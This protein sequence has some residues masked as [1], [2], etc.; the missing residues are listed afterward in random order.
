VGDLTLVGRA[1]PTL[2]SRVLP[3]HLRSET[4]SPA[5]AAIRELAEQLAA[6]GVR[7]VRGNIIADDT[8][9]VSD[10]Y[11]DDWSVGDLEWEYGAPV[12]ALAFNDNTLKLQ[13]QPGGAAGRQALIALDPVADYYQIENGVQTA[14]AGSETVI[15][16]YRAPSSM[17]LDLW[18]Q[19]PAGGETAVEEISIQNPPQLMGELLRQQLEARG[20]KVQGQ[21]MVRELTSIGAAT[22]PNPPAAPAAPRTTLAEHDSLPLREDIKLTLKVSQNLHAEMLLRTV[23]HEV[24][25]S[26]TVAAGLEVL[27]DFVA[28][29]GISPDEYFFEDGSGLSRGAMVAPD[30]VVKLLEYMSRLPHFDIFEDSLPVAGTDGT[31]ANRFIGTP[32]A[33][34]IH[35]KTGTIRHVNALSGYMELPSGDRLAFSILGN[36]DL[37]HAREAENVIDQ[38]AV[39]VYQKY[40]RQKR[41]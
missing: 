15:H 28:L 41:H 34:H 33:G 1:D 20:V 13:I 35:A 23:G 21:V 24:K 5:D 38:I 4:K 12:T 8:Y 19:I 29:A 27:K 32:A 17:K 25:N 37:L 7:Q 18:G 39:A 14:P 9:F 2:G 6:R 36:A 16:A 26:G 22:Q 3:Y 10:R 30:A 40:A 31:L 11:G